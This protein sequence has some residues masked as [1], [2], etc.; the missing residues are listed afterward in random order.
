[1]SGPGWGQGRS[2]S[3][4]VNLDWN[5]KGN[6]QTGISVILLWGNWGKEKD[7]LQ[8][9]ELKYHSSQRTRPVNFGSEGPWNHE[10]PGR[11][12]LNIGGPGSIG[13]LNMDPGSIVMPCTHGRTFD[14]AEVRREAF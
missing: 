8:K 2:E 11:G 9:L 1:M 13:K 14:H 6:L 7:Q 5:P 12:A 3:S 10:R 4:Q